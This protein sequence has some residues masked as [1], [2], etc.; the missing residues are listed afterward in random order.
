MSDLR[1][2]KAI[3]EKVD[4]SKSFD[5]LWVDGFGWENTIFQ[6]GDFVNTEQITKEIFIVTQ[7]NGEKRLMRKI[8]SL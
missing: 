7:D 8:N 1:E 6:E 5:F 2:V 3:K 4:T